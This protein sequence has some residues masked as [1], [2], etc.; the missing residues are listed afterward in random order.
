MRIEAFQKQIE[1]IYYTNVVRNVME[2]GSTER[3]AKA[4][5]HL[6]EPQGNLKT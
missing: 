3:T 6:T 4:P 1:A 5:N 2:D